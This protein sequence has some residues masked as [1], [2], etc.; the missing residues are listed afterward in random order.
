MSAA[1]KTPIMIWPP[2]NSSHLLDAKES[3]NAGAQ[4][5]M[6][7][8]DNYI[9]TRAADKIGASKLDIAAN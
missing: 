2:S 4:I 3:D 9:V 5:L 6:A 7:G 1:E 8:C